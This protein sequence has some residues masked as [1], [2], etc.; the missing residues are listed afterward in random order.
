MVSFKVTKEQVKTINKIAQR[1]NVELYADFKEQSVLDTEMDLCA[2]IAQGVQLDLDA[3][4]SFDGFNFAHDVGG[5]RRHLNRGT[6][7]LENCFLP[8]CARGQ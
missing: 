4:L 5:I 2:T 7:K 8:R 6:G 1:A 3:L